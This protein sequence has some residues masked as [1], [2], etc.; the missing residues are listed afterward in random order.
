[1]MNET[2]ENIWRS[3][4]PVPED[5]SL[6]AEDAETLREKVV[7]VKSG[8]GWMLVGVLLA[9]AVWILLY[10]LN[11]VTLVLAL[12]CV[13]CQL[14]GM[15]LCTRCPNAVRGGRGLVLV[16]MAAWGVCF[17]GCV[18]M[19]VMSITRQ[20]TLNFVFLCLMLAGFGVSGLTWQVFLI[21]LA[22]WAK[23]D[24]LVIMGWVG[25]LAMLAIIGF[26]FFPL[27]QGNATVHP[28]FGLP[29]I[30]Y[31]GIHPFMVGG[32]WREL[33]DV[34]WWMYRRPGR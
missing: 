23:S 16:S 5:D 29:A 24:K 22:L 33:M 28:V 34:E 17:A 14:Y 20:E 8:M 30:V 27:Y 6:V 26:T 12:L 2:D 32:M 4:E 10:P 9:I 18:L 3:P 21:R 15:L 25:L 19:T 11:I 31:F 7:A 13:T 1:M